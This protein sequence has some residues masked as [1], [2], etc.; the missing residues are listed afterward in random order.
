MARIARLR[1]VPIAVA[2][3]VVALA[4]GA[5]ALTTQWFRVARSTEENVPRVPRL[6]CTR[7]VD[8]GECVYGAEKCGLF[9]VRN[10]GTADLA[11]HDFMVSCTCS[12]LLRR[13]P[14]GDVPVER[15]NLAPGEE[16]Q[17]AVT[18]TVRSRFNDSTKTRIRF[19]SS[20]PSAPEVAVDVAATRVLGGLTP[21]PGSC[22]FGTVEVGSRPEQTVHLVDEAVAARPVSAV[23]SSDPDRIQ[24]TF[25]RA[26]DGRPPEV[27]NPGHYLGQLTVRLAAEKPGLIDGRVEVHYDDGSQK[28]EYVP[29]LGRVAAKLAAT[30][31]IVSLKP[32]QGGDVHVL[33]GVF[34]LRP[35]GR[36]DRAS[37]TVDKP[38]FLTLS[39]DPGEGAL[40]PVHV[41]LDPTRLSPDAESKQ[42]VKLSAVVDGVRSHVSVTLLCNP[43]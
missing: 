8:L 21:L 36:L 13:T 43:R 10:V 19:Q 11:L 28:V 17:F 3:L 39:I 4:F 20:D 1:T 16:A 26:T 41:T 15:V 40:V 9:T 31:E 5:V 2:A 34:W 38:D 33:S 6:E 37:I 32:A 35:Q 18:V 7:T 14:S 27:V 42:A 29:V 24:V 22:N 23:V 25:R 30:P 12:S